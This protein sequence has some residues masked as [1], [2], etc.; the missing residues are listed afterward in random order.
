MGSPLCLCSPTPL[1]LISGPSGV[2]KTTL[3]EQVIAES[4]L[5]LRKAIT[6]TTRAPRP[7]ERADIDYH[8]WSVDTFRSAI[9]ADEMLEYAFVHN[10]DYYGTPKSEVEPY[11]Q[12][13]IAVILV[14]DVQGT[15][16]IRQKYPNDSLSIFLAPPSFA[17]LQAR[18]QGRGESPEGITRRLKTAEKELARAGEFDHQV[19]NADI[20]TTVQELDCLL[21]TLLSNR[22]SIPCSTN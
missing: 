21:R 19:I 17:D 3:V 15:A 7:G 9:D 12:T 6:C 4:E 13:G 22:G 8:Y 5:P 18:L 20:T 16:Q 1:I 2:G 14:I 10:R 11:R